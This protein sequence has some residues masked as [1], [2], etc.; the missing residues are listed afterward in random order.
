MTRFSGKIVVPPGY[1]I[2]FAPGAQPHY[3]EANWGSNFQLAMDAQPTLITV[4]NAGIPAFL[5]NV[6]DPEVIRILTAPMRAAEIY[7]EVKKGDW[8][9]LSAQFPV[10]ESVGQVTSYGDWNENGNT[11][12]NINWVARQ[13]YH[14][15][16][17]SQYGERELDMYG[18]AKLDYK[19]EIDVAAAL[20]VSKYMNLSYFFGI[21]GLANYGALNDPGLITPVGPTG[22]TWPTATGDV[23]YADILKLFG[24]LQT[25]M[26]GLTKN[27]ET[28]TLAMSPTSQVYLLKTNIYGISVEDLIKKN[29]PNMTVKTAPEYTT[30]GGELVQMIINTFEGTQTG[31]AAFTEKMRAHPIV[32]G[33]SNFKQKKSAGTW[34]FI[35][36]RPICVAQLLGV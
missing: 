11:G 32:Q 23:I 24:Q 4:S 12:A 1:G 25:Q 18:A 34:G 30:T 27:D 9:T 21:T 29:F 3:Q 22:A 36:R 17:V 5:T 6:I 20:V 33:L 26:A 14:F 7:G 8:T 2:H 35:L 10:V 19:S 28:L 13:S 15:Q 31:Y 16:T